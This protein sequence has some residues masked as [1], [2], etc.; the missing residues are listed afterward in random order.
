MQYNIYIKLIE[1]KKEASLEKSTKELEKKPANKL[2]NVFSSCIPLSLFSC[3]LLALSLPLSFLVC[4]RWI[5]AWADWMCRTVRF[6]DVYIK[7]AERKKGEKIEEWGR[8]T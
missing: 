4:L 8:E 6:R 7:S 2:N 5:I 3:I 1:A